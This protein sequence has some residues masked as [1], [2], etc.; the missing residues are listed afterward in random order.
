MNVYF[1]SGL[2]ADRQAF[3]RIQLDSKHHIFHIDWLVPKKKESLSEYA[4]RMAES[5][6]KKQAFA[7]IGLS[8]GGIM[9]I[10]INKLFPAKK[11]ILVSSVSSFQELPWYFKLAGKLQIHRLG[12][13]SLIKKKKAFLHYLFGVHTPNMKAYLN[14]MI[15]KT[16]SYYLTWSLHTIL[17]W[18][19]EYKPLDTI[20]I[21]GNKDL[22]FPIRYINADVI[23]ENGSHFM[24]MTHASKISKHINDAL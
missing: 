24:I 16:D 15:D 17:N 14:E 6:D 5:I 3:Q 12:F 1:I 10:E 23:I 2:G 7:L 18:K 22:L 8:F 9:A 21:H 13:S 4:L 19:N 20:H 11:I